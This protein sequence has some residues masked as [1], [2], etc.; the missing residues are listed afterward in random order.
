MN[1]F[2][3]QKL[4]EFISVNDFGK[5]FKHKAYFNPR[6]RTTGGRY[7]LTTHNIDI[8]PKQFE[9]HGQGE[10]EKIIKHELCHY[11]LHLEK[12]GYMHKDD[13]FK[14]L[15]KQVGGT[16]FCK[17]LPNTRS[18]SSKVHIYECRKCGVQFKR[19]RQFDTSKYVCG[20]CKGRIK[21]V[22]TNLVR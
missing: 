15:L 10:L 9:Y 17:T 12:K 21:K 13:D 11:H 19:R 2:E 3:L 4:V 5:P 22:V 6:L 7:S 20:K 1:D 18:S 16:R 14:L 8:N